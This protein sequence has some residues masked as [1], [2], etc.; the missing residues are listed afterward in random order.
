MID[1]IPIYTFYESP[2]YTV[3]YH[4]DYLDGLHI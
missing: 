2:I 3:L 1:T 4:L